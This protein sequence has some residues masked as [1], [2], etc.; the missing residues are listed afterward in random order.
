[1][2]VLLLLG[3][4]GTISHSTCETVEVE[5]EEDDALG[6]LDFTVG[7][8]VT[9][10]TG[11]RTFPTSLADDTVVSAE[12]VV[13]RADAPAV[14]FDATLG[15]SRSPRVGFG[16]ATLGMAVICEDSVAVPMDLDLTTADGAVDLLAGVDATSDDL[17]DDPGPG[18]DTVTLRYTLDPEVDVVPR[19]GDTPGELYVE[20]VGAALSRLQVAWDVPDESGVVLQFPPREAE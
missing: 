2:L 4:F 13:T 17:G 7:D 10:V 6:D 8:L 15:T 14:F 18:V 20:F 11:V 12:L 9:A 5:V 19:R 1:M 3:C 16:D